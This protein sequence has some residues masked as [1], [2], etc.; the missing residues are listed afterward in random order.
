MT[1]KFDI[2]DFMREQLI[3]LSEDDKID[4][5]LILASYNEEIE[6]RIHDTIVNYYSEELG[7]E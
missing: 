2:F 1:N 7:E 6:Y 5:T 4:L 3:Y